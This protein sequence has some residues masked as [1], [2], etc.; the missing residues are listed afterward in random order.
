MSVDIFDPCLMNFVVRI[1]NWAPLVL[2][3]ACL[4]ACSNKNIF[5]DRKYILLQAPRGCKKSSIAYDMDLGLQNTVINLSKKYSPAWNFHTLR[6]VVVWRPSAHF[7]HLV[8]SRHIYHPGISKGNL[9]TSQH[10]QN[11]SLWCGIRK[12]FLLLSIIS[13]KC[14]QVN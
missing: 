6:N 2:Y 11:L 10:A 1:K 3:I 9:R 8:L 13:I 4:W 7:P 12:M 5:Y 14:G